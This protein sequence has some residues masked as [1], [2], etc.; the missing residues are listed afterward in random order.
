[1]L[2]ANRWSLFG[3]KGC[4]GSTQGSSLPLPLVSS[5]KGAQPCAAA[6]SPVRPKFLVSSQPTT[7]R[8]PLVHSVSFESSANCRWWVLK[9]V[10]TNTYLPLLGSYSAS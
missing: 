2:T 3:P 7:S 8:P 5:T 9:Q 6:A 10:S 4:P 1:M